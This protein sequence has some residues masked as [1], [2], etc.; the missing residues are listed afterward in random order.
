MKKRGVCL[1]LIGILLVLPIVFAE[2]QVQ[3]DNTIQEQTQ[4]QTYSGFSRFMDNTKLFFSSGDNKVEIALEIRE[5]EVNSAINNV[6]NQ[7]EEKAI[8][9]LERAR[10]KL[11]IVQ[12]KVSLNN[13]E[14]IRASVEEVT[15]K[16]NANSALPEI[17]DDYLLEEEKTGLT[18]VLTEKTYE[19]CKELAKEDYNL[20]LKEKE[21]NPDS[22]IPGLE[23]ELKDLKDLQFRMFVQLMLEIRSCIDDPGTCNCEN[24]LDIEQKA[25]CEKM[26]ALAIKCEYKEDET[27]CDELEAMK[28]SPGDG[29]ARSFVPSF[30][31]NLFAKK[32]TMI[33]YG[34]DHSDGVPEECWN[35]NNKPECEKYANLK[36]NNLDWDEYGNYRPILY[37]G[38]HPSS[39]GID[40]TKPTV[41]ESIPQCFDEEGN[42]LE[43]KCGK[44]SVVW[45]EEGLINYIIG[46]EVDNV[47]EEFENKSEQHLMEIR[48]G[49]M[50]VDGKWVIDPGQS[51]NETHTID[52][53]KN[54]TENKAWEIKQEMDQIQNQ[55]MNIT[56]A[57]GTT[58]GGGGGVVYEGGKQKIVAGDENGGEPGVV[59]EG[60]ENEVVTG[61]HEENNVVN[62]V[63]EGEENREGSGSNGDSGGDEAVIDGG[64]EEGPS[65]GDGVVCD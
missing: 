2:E 43:E 44:I 47:I 55:I 24:N 8:K 32:Y 7:G 9:N 23:D 42:F 18:A 41:Q 27:S 17:F 60:G 10:E 40:E 15:N 3:T 28:P 49:W 30:L 52:K 50:M 58:A 12:E 35:E 46:N 22:A 59:I 5:K 33:E 31:M 21:C 25:K 65:C 39:G 63:I 11:M 4:L 61:G 51:N 57:E 36:E 53:G 54:Q 64:G 29:F 13:S 26:V 20:M 34:I 6:Q 1:V 14:E 37:P 56:Y 45:N 48:K 38:K 16:I 62:N 19:Y